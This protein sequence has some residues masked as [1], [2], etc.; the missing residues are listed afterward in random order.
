MQN[1]RTTNVSTPSNQLIHQPCPATLGS[2]IYGLPEINIL[3]HRQGGPQSVGDKFNAYSTSV[4]SPTGTDILS[5]WM[6]RS[7]VSVICLID[8]EAS[9]VG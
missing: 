2:T 7:L 4:L 9:M 1:Q 3:L 8:D 5:F 6:V